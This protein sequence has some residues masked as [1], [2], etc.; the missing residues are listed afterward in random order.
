MC[1]H[2][3]QEICEY[4]KKICECEMDVEYTSILYY[5]IDML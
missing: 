2:W 3:Q 5:K 1:L 4:P